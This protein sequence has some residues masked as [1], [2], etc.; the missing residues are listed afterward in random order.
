MAKAEIRKEQE[1]GPLLDGLK[2]LMF[3]ITE[4]NTGNICKILKTL[5][6][7]KEESGT[8]FKT[9][10]ATKHAKVLTN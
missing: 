3:Q 10:R 7:K 5:K 8:E 1:E 4:Q 2:K 6:T 9:A